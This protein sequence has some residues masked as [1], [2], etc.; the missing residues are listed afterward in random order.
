M[1]LPR[2]DV[3]LNDVVCLARRTDAVEY[4]EIVLNRN[5]NDCPVGSVSLMDVSI[6]TNCSDFQMAHR[7]LWP[8]FGGFTLRHGHN[9]GDSNLIARWLSN[10][11]T[12]HLMNVALVAQTV[13]LRT[14]SRPVVSERLNVRQ[15]PPIHHFPNSPPIL[16]RAKIMTHKRK[17][18]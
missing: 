13:Q 15:L 9:F 17:L 4:T 10:G 3:S 11:A 5:V 6:I 12:V 8:L 1:I 14:V 18:P 2:Q 16:V 7:K